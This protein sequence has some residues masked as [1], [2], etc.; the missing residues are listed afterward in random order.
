[1]AGAGGTAAAAHAHHT[2]SI[3]AHA[4]AK[5]PL[6]P[7]LRPRCLSLNMTHLLSE[8]IPCGLVRSEKLLLL[9]LLVVR[10]ARAAAAPQVIATS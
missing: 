8:S 4:V 1:M 7:L 5:Q 9:L 2:T 6:A 10:T 3:F